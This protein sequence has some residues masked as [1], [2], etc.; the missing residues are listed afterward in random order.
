M[1]CP[2]ALGA[3]LIVLLLVDAV[4]AWLA[5]QATF[6]LFEILWR[7]VAGRENWR[8]LVEAHTHQFT[9]LRTV[10][11]VAWMATTAIF[12]WWVRRLRA[13][14]MPAEPH[15]DG[16]S[17]LR[18]WRWMAQTW[19]A[20]VPGVAASRTPPLL[21][22]WWALLGGVVGVEGWALVRY[23]VTGTP[24]ELGRG[25]MLVLVASALEIALAV[26]TIFL[27]VAIQRGVA[28]PPAASR[29]R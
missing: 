18:P 19:R 3:A 17:T 13:R 12:V 14:L 4:L 9:R 15:G 5:I 16:A 1:T 28:R 21:A 6:V 29:P 11:A 25:L 10:E 22:W 8:P 2:R 26:V 23:L 20:A 27:V 24:F 7:A